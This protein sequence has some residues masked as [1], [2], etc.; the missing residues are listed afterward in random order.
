MELYRRCPGKLYKCFGTLKDCQVGL[1]REDS[2]RDGAKEECAGG[3]GGGPVSK[4]AGHHL[5]GFA[6]RQ[7]VSW[8]PDT[9]EH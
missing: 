1:C 6:E 5:A 3:G 4:E 9:A 2:P 7:W 8:V